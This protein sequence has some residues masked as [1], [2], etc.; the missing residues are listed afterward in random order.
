MDEL[1][2]IICREID[3]LGK[4][5]SFYRYLELALFHPIHGYYCRS[6]DRVGHRKE[7]DFYTASS[8]GPLFGQL[9]LSAIK[10]LLKNESLLD[11][12]FVEIGVESGSGI[13]DSW[14]ED[15]FQETF[16]FGIQD[17]LK[18]TAQKKVVFSNE[19]FDAQ[20]F[21]RFRYLEGEGWRE[22]GVHHK[23]GELQECLLESFSMEGVSVQ[24]RFQEASTNQYHVDYPVG[25][26]KLLKEILESE[27]TGLFLAFDYGKAWRSIL[28]ESP[29]GTART[30]QNHQMGIDL[31]K[32]PGSLDITHHICWDHLEEILN[33]NFFRDI[34]VLR[35]ESFFMNF[36][37]LA[38][39]HIMQNTQK[40]IIG[41]RGTLMELL[42]PGNM[43]AK[44]QVLSGIKT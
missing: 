25:A 20:P 9:V 35:Q 40:G 44:F 26:E 8:L 28:Y 32:T 7:A 1:Q 10:K 11:Y 27:W 12:Q 34:K 30:Y 6:S 22:L 33:E 24:H 36:S 5:I 21:C 19:L 29:Q 16:A 23:E 17:K 4:P 31:L 15:E 37:L 42:H 2:K 38:I 39:E 3:S 43:G 14:G 41:G 18:L 13:S